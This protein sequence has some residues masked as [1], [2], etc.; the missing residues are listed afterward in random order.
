MLHILTYSAILRSCRQSLL[1][2][3]MGHMRLP[4]STYKIQLSSQFTLSELYDL[5]DYFNDLGIDM[6]YLSPLQKAVAGSCHGYDVVDHSQL[7]PE[8]G[9]EGDLAVLSERLTSINMGVL[10]DIVPN[11]MY[12]TDP[13]NL[14]WQSVLELGPK[15]PYAHFFDIDLHFGL[16]DLEGKVLQPFLG[17]GLFEAIESGSLTLEESEGKT[18]FCYGTLRFPCDPT[19]EVSL[20]A[21]NWKLDHWQRGCSDCNYRRFFN[22]SEL[23]CLN[24]EKQEVFNTVHALIFR[25]IEKGWIQGLRIDHVDG[26][27]DPATYLRNLQEFTGGIYVVVEKI[28]GPQE[29][30]PDKWEASGTTGYEFANLS[31]GLYIQNDL[32]EIWRE[33]TGIGQQ[34]EHVVRE[35]KQRV[36]STSMLS[37]WR[38]LSK[39]VP[40]HLHQDLMELVTSLPIYRT[41]S[42]GELT[43]KEMPLIERSS[44]PLMTWM[45]ENPEY[46]VKLQQ[47]TGP[48]MAKGYEDTALYRF[49]PMTALNEVG[50]HLQITSVEHFHEEMKIRSPLALSA[51]T[52]HDTKRSEDV[53][54]RIAVLSEIPEY[55]RKALSRFTELTDFPDKNLAYLFYQTIVGTWPLENLKRSDH[56][57]YVDRIAAYLLKAAKEQNLRTSWT[58]P[59]PNFEAQLHHSVHEALSLG[60]PF[61][62]EADGIIRKLILPGLFNALSTVLLKMTAPGV[63]DI[64]QGCELW[65]SSLVDPDNRRKVDFIKR[66]N[67]LRNIFDLDEMMENITDGRLKLFVTQKLL[68][69][70]KNLPALFLTGSYVPLEAKRGIAFAR[71]FGKDKIIAVT[72]RF[73][74]RRTPVE[75]LLPDNETYQDLFTSKIYQGR[76]S[77]C[78]KLPIACLVRIGK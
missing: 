64:Y 65:T 52:T 76:S 6:L 29:R 43:E 24:V 69:L 44:E 22:I 8:I 28:L 17:E 61:Y 41:Y 47:M 46:I 75:I 68:H 57:I 60:S 4:L 45:Q 39:Q 25:W 7:N 59:D 3:M 10:L 33:F 63:P 70:R 40:S 48:I 58:D 38:A 53:R 20:D 26:L 37:E 11:H 19:K 54:A 49:I 77:V 36:L 71:E 2:S 13:S 72:G 55:W 23:A 30:L 56:K 62:R 51:S 34:F 12:I 15:S 14:L 32:Q 31:Q 66:Q 5:V 67:M 1:L 9:N 42:R 74:T 27:A 73:F 78:G 21:Q 50:S 35:C 18:R 16:P